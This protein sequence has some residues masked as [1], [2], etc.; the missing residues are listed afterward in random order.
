MDVRFQHELL[1]LL[2]EERQTVHELMETVSE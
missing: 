2:P 1:S